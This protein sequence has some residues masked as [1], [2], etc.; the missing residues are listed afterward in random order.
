[1]EKPSGRKWSK[2]K[3]KLKISQAD[4]EGRDADLVSADTP[5][6]CLSQADGSKQSADTPTEL[7]AQVGT[8]EKSA[9]TPVACLSQADGSTS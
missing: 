4:T 9:D 7:V 1:V 6:A 5:A 3:A 2:R 8:S